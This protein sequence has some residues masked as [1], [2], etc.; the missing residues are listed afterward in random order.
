MCR[1]KRQQPCM[2]DRKDSV[3]S[4]RFWLGFL[5]SWFPWGISPWHSHWPL[6]C[7]PDC[8]CSDSSTREKQHHPCGQEHCTTLKHLTRAAAFTQGRT[9]HELTTNSSVGVASNIGNHILH[10]LSASRGWAPHRPYCQT[11]RVLGMLFA[12]DVQGAPAHLQGNSSLRA[13]PEPL[14]CKISYYLLRKSLLHHP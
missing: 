2:E 9:W 7:C 6:W 10:C 11:R 5:K 14:R 1:I 3:S 13:T 8:W 12:Q 4:G